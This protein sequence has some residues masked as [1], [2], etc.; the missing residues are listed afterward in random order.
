MILNILLTILAYFLGSIPSSV[1][2]GRKF[3]GIDVREHGSKNAGTTNTLRVLGRKAAIPVFAID[4]LKGFA[5]VKLSMITDLAPESSAI[6]YLKIFLIVAVVLGHIFPIFVGF[7]GG[8]GVATVAG[9][10]LGMTTIPLLIALAIFFVS[11]AISKYVS[12][13]SMI[14]GISYPLLLLF[15]F[16]D[17]LEQILFGCIIA[18]ALV[19]THRKNIGRLIRGEESKIYLIKSWKKK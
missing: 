15:I 7:K 3:Y 5:A 8:K 11:L 4:F 1:W 18:I 9:A 10:A 14:A 2:I 19:V 6:F 16:H 17:S 13:S 12:L